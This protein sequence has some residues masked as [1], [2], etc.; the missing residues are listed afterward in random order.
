VF[1]LPTGCRLDRGA[2]RGSGRSTIDPVA[3]VVIGACS[4]PG[5]ADVHG[6]AVDRNRYIDHSAKAHVTAE[7]ISRESIS[8]LHDHLS[9]IVTGLFGGRDRAVISAC[10]SPCAR[11]P[12]FDN[13]PRMS[14]SPAKIARAA[15][16]MPSRYLP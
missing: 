15:V 5:P 8:A 6:L 2:D 11:M 3:I 9:A 1:Q 12:S 10:T 16:C 7:R 14:Y 13:A 4:P